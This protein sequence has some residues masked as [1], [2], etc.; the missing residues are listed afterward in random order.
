MFS[1]L[2][3]LQKRGNK[4]VKNVMYTKFC[5]G[6]KLIYNKLAK[7]TLSILYDCTIQ[8]FHKQM[9]RNVHVQIVKLYKK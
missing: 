9:Q 7:I 4:I 3:S 2:L 1:F 5:Y 6:K 8:E